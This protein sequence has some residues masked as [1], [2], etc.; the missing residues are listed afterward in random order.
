[1]SIPAQL[2]ESLRAHDLGTWAVTVFGQLEGLR[3]SFIPPYPRTGNPRVDDVW[4]IGGELPGKK[5]PDGADAAVFAGQTIAR[6]LALGEN[7]RRL[8]TV[9]KALS[10]LRKSEETKDFALIVE[11]FLREE[12]RIALVPNDAL[13]QEKLVIDTA[14]R[15]IRARV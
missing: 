11:R 2:R 15:P 5:T 3:P 10:A 9:I 1:M 8:R 14:R 4:R 7:E 6:S 13:S 12:W